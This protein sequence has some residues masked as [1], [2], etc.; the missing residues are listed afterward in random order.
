[1]SGGAERALE[2]P[3]L[4]RDLIAFVDPAPRS[5]DEVMAAWRTACPRLTIWEDALDRGYVR[6][7]PGG[8]VEATAEGRAFLRRFGA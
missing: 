4:V 6:R 1:M 7:A 3:A 8:L 2:N 5:Y